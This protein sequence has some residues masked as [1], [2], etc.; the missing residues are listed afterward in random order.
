MEWT[1]INSKYSQIYA[2]KIVRKKLIIFIVYSLTGKREFKFLINFYL[3]RKKKGKI[4]HDR[5]LCDDGLLELYIINTVV[6]WNY[7]LLMF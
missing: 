7:I 2:E 5:K 3:A 4:F 1:E 6:F